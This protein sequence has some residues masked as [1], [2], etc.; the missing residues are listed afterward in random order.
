MK[1]NRRYLL[2]AGILI[3]LVCVGT[4]VYYGMQNRHVVFADENMAIE[5]CAVLGEDVQP[6]E[7][8][9]KDLANITE[10]RI[11]FLG[12]YETL[13]D[14]QKCYALES[15]YVNGYGGILNEK[16]DDGEMARVLTE[17]E[18]IQ[19]QE[20]L[21][22]IVPTLRHLE[23]FIYVNPEQ[24]A[25]LR[26]MSF[27]TECRNLKTLY[28]SD[29]DIAD[30]SFL[31]KCTSLEKINLAGSSIKTADMLMNL[32]ELWWIC[33]FDTPLSENEEEV[34]RLCEAYPDAKILISVDRIQN[35]DLKK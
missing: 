31:S 7:V 33:I 4:L 32:D 13:V 19:M 29:S 34:T 26:D 30:Y 10:L 5:I 23:E 21:A 22:E 3:V 24:N 35:E 15:L 14:I 1:K 20:E 9:Y 27:V 17:E 25:D 6:E 16:M 12:H 18:N 8:R 2:V 28:I 11:G